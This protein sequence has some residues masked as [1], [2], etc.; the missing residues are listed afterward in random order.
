[1]SISVSQALKDVQQVCSLKS[2]E[3]FLPLHDFHVDNANVLLNESADNGWRWVT[4]ALLEGDWVHM[5]H[6]TLVLVVFRTENCLVHLDDLELRSKELCHDILQIPNGS[7]LQVLS[8][9]MFRTN[10]E[11]QRLELN[12]V[13]LVQI[14]KFVGLHTTSIEWESVASVDLLA[15]VNKAH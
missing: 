3:V 12:Q 8:L 10:S 2:F 1:M 11:V 5:R 15:S 4:K 7:C 13:T 6:P 9:K 14:S